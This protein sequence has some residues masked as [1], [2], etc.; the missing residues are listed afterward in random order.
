MD[1]FDLYAKISLDP[2]EFERGLDAASKKF[3]TFSDNI[4][5]ISEKV[6]KAYSGLGDLLAPAVDGYKAVESVG[7]KAGDTV[8]KGVKTFGA[9][10]AAVGGFGAT[11]VKSGMQFD[12]TMSEVS[13]ISGA[14]GEDFDA[15]RDKA[16]EMGA[17]T[18]FSASEAA[19]AMTYMG[20]AGWKSKD[21]ISGISGI[22]DLAAASGEDLATTS[23]I[24]TDA[25][26]AFGL[27]ASDSGHFADIMA[28]ASSN[29]NTNVGLMGE[30]FKYVAPVAGALGYSAEDTA[31]AIGLMANSGI[32]ASQAGTSL[33]TAMTNMASPTKNMAA[34]M[35]KYDLSL[36]DA[37]GNMKSL[38]EIMEE[39]RLKMGDVDAAT[40]AA[41]ASLLF[42]KEAM[43]GMLAIINASTEDYEKLTAAIYDCDDAAQQMAATMVDNLQGDLTLLGSAFESLQIAI[44]DSLTPTLREF[45]QFGQKAMAEL[46]NG[47][48]GD[49]VHGF[50][51]ALSGIVSDAVTILAEKAPMF[52][53]VSMQFILAFGEGIIKS[54]DAI[55]EAGHQVVDILVGGIHSFMAN[56]E[57]SF[58]DFGFQIIELIASGFLEA[59]EVISMYIGDFI[60]L[61]AEAFAKYHEALFT[62]GMDI[63]GAIGKGIVENKEG[64]AQTASQTISNMV[65]SFKE[66]APDIIEGAVALIDA[67]V[68]GLLEN[69]DLITETAVE[70]I[71][72]FV[73]GVIDALPGILEAAVKII[74]ALGEGIVA[75]LPE[76]VS[77]IPE[78]ITAIVSTIVENLPKILEVGVQIV[79]GLAEG[80]VKAIP[81]LIK[82]IPKLVNA[83]IDGVK[84][85]LG[86]H[87]P[88]KVFEEIGK[89][90]VLGLGGG[91]KKNTGGIDEKTEAIVAA[92]KDKFAGMPDFFFGIG[93]N[94]L[95]SLSGSLGAGID[96]LKN[97]VSDLMSKIADAAKAALGIHS[98]SKV[99]AGIGE[100]MALG[101]AEGWDDQYSSI[102]RQIENGMSFGPANVGL[103]TSRLTGGAYYGQDGQPGQNVRDGDTF[104]FY[105]PKA[106][107]PVSAAREMK[108][109][110]QQMALAYV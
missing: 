12:A 40:Q 5:G 55:V 11:A 15:L 10:S 61:I 52:A 37:G 83:L 100:N 91:I 43:S 50:M 14:T 81:E 36:T 90:V 24:V 70:V 1:L 48:Q 68:N 110:K 54:R 78:I 82:S 19:E 97:K 8:V 41:D 79:L 107:D 86:I 59:G 2:S 18:K 75:S 85:L 60:P 94:A 51:N 46:L 74:I 73:S 65:S 13:A 22:M 27:Q 76:L 58:I 80:L 105:S 30:T 3:K 32:K 7:K 98:P 29:A 35:D 104:N 25:L 38:A 77:K 96:K 87:S 69:I 67:L 17:K 93:N 103:R 109:A 31:V 20:M 39:L 89:N 9:I 21:M 71:P 16:L 108:K 102:K 45:A 106:L 101:L 66:N 34:V 44:S 28:A 99:F 57:G 4:K 92:M 49:G 6:D 64:I 62:V 26:T 42:G 56:Y 95:S 72:A 33:R 23:D 88:S 47:F 63:L 84:D 53:G